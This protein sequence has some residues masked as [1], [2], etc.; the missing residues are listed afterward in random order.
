MQ[1]T[2]LGNKTYKHEDN[3]EEKL[4]HWKMPG[5]LVTIKAQRRSLACLVE[6]RTLAQ[7]RNPKT[8]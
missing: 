7:G 6:S 5:R 3:S 1:G 4:L 8:K 2:R